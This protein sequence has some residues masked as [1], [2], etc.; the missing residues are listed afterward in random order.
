MAP[1]LFS[2]I[3]KSVSEHLKICL[4]NYINILV[5]KL[6]ISVCLA[7]HLVFNKVLINI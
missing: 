4:A 7:L 2:S 3:P 6:S 5:C 1:A